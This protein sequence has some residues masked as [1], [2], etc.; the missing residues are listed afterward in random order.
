VPGRHARLKPDL[1][2]SGVSG[3]RGLLTRSANLV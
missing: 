1:A 2:L 3:T